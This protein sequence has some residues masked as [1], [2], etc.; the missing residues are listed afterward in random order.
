M[1]CLPVAGSS[2]ACR[3]FRPTPPEPVVG[4]LIVALMVVV[5]RIAADVEIHFDTVQQIPL[6]LALF[7][8]I[9]LG[10]DLASLNAG[11]P[12]RWPS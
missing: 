12:A 5:M 1:S 2:S 6:M 3:C 11:G 9:G 8:T 10:A 7:A 4:G